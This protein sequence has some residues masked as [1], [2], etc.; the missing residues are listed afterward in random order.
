MLNDE[1]P[2]IR[3][4][5]RPSWSRLPPPDEPPALTMPSV[6][7]GNHRQE[8]GASPAVRAER[9]PLAL[10]A[11]GP[12]GLMWRSWC[13]ASCFRKN[14]SAANCARGVNAR[15]ASVTTSHRRRRIVEG[16]E[17]RRRDI[18]SVCVGGDLVDGSASGTPAD[19]PLD[20]PDVVFAEHRGGNRS[21]G[22]RTPG[23][24]RG[25]H[26]ALDD[27][28]REAAA[29]H[30]FPLIRDGGCQ[31]KDIQNC[32]IRK[33]AGASRACRARASSSFQK[34]AQ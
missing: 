31:Y 8:R 26:V 14:F 12:L 33:S 11:P 5:R 9:E 10:P 20:R 27:V 16:H 6:E 17:R 25:R 13:S 4:N 32:A 19:S 29:R 18:A 1:S 28:A 22:Q 15:R 21:C 23:E 7:R 24:R 30:R 2:D 34:E 3:W